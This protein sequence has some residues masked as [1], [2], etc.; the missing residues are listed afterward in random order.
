VRI[1]QNA[2]GSGWSGFIDY[3]AAEVFGV[4]IFHRVFRV[5]ASVCCGF[6]VVSGL[7][8]I[9]TSLAEDRV[10]VADISCEA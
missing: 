1:F 6:G 3:C 2:R 4:A 7:S 5:A 9:F 10:K 8:G